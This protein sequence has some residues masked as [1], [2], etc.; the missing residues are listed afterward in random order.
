[1]QCHDTVATVGTLIAGPDLSFA[2]PPIKLW[3]CMRF[4]L[5]REVKIQSQ[6]VLH[7]AAAAAAASV[8]IVT[9]A[10]GWQR[11][12]KRSPDIDYNLVNLMKDAPGGHGRRTCAL[13]YFRNGRVMLTSAWNEVTAGLHK[14]QEAV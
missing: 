10:A 13:R 11:T 7:A 3:V 4:F 8:A 14:A 12:S 2:L 9:A 1:M 5:S 6:A